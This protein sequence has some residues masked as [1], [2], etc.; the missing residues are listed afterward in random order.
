M[1][2]YPPKSLQDLQKLN[3]HT[4]VFCVG[5]SYPVSRQCSHSIA[6]DQDEELRSAVAKLRSLSKE[7]LKTH[8][9]GLMDLL[10][11]VARGFSCK[12]THRDL[13]GQAKQLP[14][15][16]IALDSL[17]D[18]L[19]CMGLEGPAG[20]ECLPHKASSIQS[21]VN[22]LAPDEL[23]TVC[24]AMDNLN[25]NELDQWWQENR[26]GAVAACF[27]EALNKKFEID[28]M[29]DEKK[30]KHRLARDRWDAWHQSLEPSK[31][32][33]GRADVDREASVSGDESEH[34]LALDATPLY[35]LAGNVPDQQRLRKRRIDAADKNHSPGSP[36]LM[37]GPSSA[38][39][40]TQTHCQSVRG[41]VTPPRRVTIPQNGLGRP[42]ALQVP[43]RRIASDTKATKREQV[44][45]DLVKPRCGSF[46][47]SGTN[48]SGA[49]DYDT[50]ATAGTP[51]EDILRFPIF[52]ANGEPRSVIET[53]RR[54]FKE[55]R[56]P[57]TST[58]SRDQRMK[59]VGYIYAFSMPGY[60][61]YIKIGRTKNDIRLRQKQIQACAGW[62]LKMFN[63]GD[64]CPVSNHQKVEKLIHEALQPFRRKFSCN[65]KARGSCDEDKNVVEHSEWFEIDQDHAVE[66]I[67]RW[68]GWMNSNPYCNRQLKSN[69]DLRIDL[70]DRRL[71]YL[72]N[73]SNK[74]KDI[75]YFDWD[76]FMRFPVWQR[77]QMQ[78]N[79]C[80]HEDRPDRD[81]TS[82]RWNS[83]WK[84]WQLNFICISYFFLLSFVTT[85]AAR[86]VP[87]P[88]GTLVLACLTGS[89][90]SLS[91]VLYAA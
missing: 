84:H 71:T 1:I 18:F 36:Q 74:G 21:A 77:I 32:Y 38:P 85:V 24:Q 6:F 55:M 30:R 4:T 87:W 10:R 81:D 41:P 20:E 16:W 53:T 52:E 86:F 15:Y 23:M 43:G 91:A 49:A 66:T 5:R 76:A 80:L 44:P 70:H 28:E 27:R 58:T 45:R 89:L 72:S 26:N 37:S 42:N 83:A 59:D 46:S 8:D 63:E 33:Y 75:P 82:P 14:Y 2:L 13:P 54:V 50:P 35:S 7:G 90:L 47:S 62:K 31:N 64:Y 65:C 11:V 19:S 79:L 61:G 73:G 67:S 48:M 9:L 88:V 40:A 68:R 56:K 69:E 39:K 51:S 29:D 17:P 12:D 57:L 78:I 3:D 60:P 34:S 25:Y 22:A